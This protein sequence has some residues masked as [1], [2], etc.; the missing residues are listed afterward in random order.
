MRIHGVLLLIIMFGVLF[1]G[2][3][4]EQTTAGIAVG[5]VVTG[6]SPEVV[7]PDNPLEMLVRQV[8]VF[9]GVSKD[10]DNYPLSEV[11]WYP[12]QTQWATNL[13]N[14]GSKPPDDNWHIA[15]MYEDSSS[16]IWIYVSTNISLLDSVSEALTKYEPLEQTV[17]VTSINMTSVSLLATEDQSGYAA[18]FNDGVV[19]IVVISYGMSLDDMK[20]LL[21]SIRLISLNSPLLS[22]LQEDL[23][24]VSR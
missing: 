16:T 4:A 24:A 23:N 11:I 14:I 8:P 6:V 5:A 13:P 12:S 20:Q 1:S 21:A 7:W 10:Q 3:R 22:E 2:C 18:V 15:S 9:Y 19:D 17:D